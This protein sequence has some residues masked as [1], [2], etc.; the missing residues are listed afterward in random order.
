VS[1]EPQK[2]QGTSNPPFIATAPALESLALLDRGLGSR[3]PFVLVTG[4]SGVG[5]TMLVREALRRW[6]GRVCVRHVSPHEATPETLF[7]TLLGRFGG[8]E[9]SQANAPALTQRLLDA[10]LHAGADGKVTVVVV[11]DAH[12][13]APELLAQFVSVAD[14]VRKRECAFEVLLVGS[15]GLA[16]RLNDPALA[17]LAA[18]VGAQVRLSPLTQHDTR[19]YLLQRGGHDVGAAGAGMFSRKACR[20]VHGATFGIPRAIEALADEA[21]R[22]AAKA[23]ATI[24]S[25]EH[26]RSATQSLRARRGHAPATVIAPRAERMGTAPKPA[27][28]AANGSSN[29]QPAPEPP[30]Q[31]AAEATGSATQPAEAAASPA[32]KPATPAVKA[33]PA[34]AAP[35]PA[36]PVAKPAPA[37]PAAKSAPATQTAKPAPAAKPVAAAPVTTK[38]EPATPARPANG[39]AKS[40]GSNDQRVKDWVSR[41]GGSGGV[42]IGVGHSMPRYEESATLD[43]PARAATSRIGAAKETSAEAEAKPANRILI[44][45]QEPA[46]PPELVARLNKLTKQKRRRGP[47]TTIQG[48][49]LAVAVMLLV[50]VLARHAGFGRNLGFQPADT[51]TA[52]APPAP[53]P[54]PLTLGTGEEAGRAKPRPK[55]TTRTTEEPK[56]AERVTKAKPKPAAV[57][58][59]TRTPVVAETLPPVRVASTTPVE[60]VTPLGAGETE[61]PANSPHKFGIIAGAFPTNDMAKAEKDHLARLTT[62][63]VW[64]DKTKVSGQRTYHLMVGRFETMER[65][66]D[67]GQTLMRRGLIRDANVRPLSEREAR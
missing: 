4:D 31:A 56:V 11:D 8:T 21:A 59:T 32:V 23:G 36:P 46:F 12:T 65:A 24:I 2:P 22:R 64:I 39:D 44:V 66:W 53:A 3:E 50:V 7:A 35:K 17:A 30:K 16:A 19:H 5:K 54:P 62:Y 55:S 43:V 1:V 49:G 51:S 27:G 67:A 34:A 57:K 60:T 25:P 52:V 14:M 29:A 18:K 33:V 9:N 13:A 37:A 63:R 45:D 40:P 28:P 41:F 58:L 42:R 15:T 20:D 47:S 6:G 48:A 26:V 38:A 61:A 10:I